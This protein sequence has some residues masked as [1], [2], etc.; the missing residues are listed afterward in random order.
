[1]DALDRADALIIHTQKTDSATPRWQFVRPEH[2]AGK[3][4][5]QI[6]PPPYVTPEIVEFVRER[7]AAL[8]VHG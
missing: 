1:M 8:A 2:L 3:P 7:L 6:Q 5:F 4:T